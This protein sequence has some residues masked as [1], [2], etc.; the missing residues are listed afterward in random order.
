MKRP[1]SRIVCGDWVIYKAPV[2]VAISAMSPDDW[3]AVHTIYRAGI[4][5][6]QATFETTIPSW[7]EWDASKRPDCRLVAR[8]G[9]QVVGWAALNP[10]SKR[11]VYAGVAEVSI[12]VADPARGQGV[13]RLLLRALIEAAEKAGIWTLQAS[14]FP[15]NEA[16]IGLFLA[17][18]FRIVGY[19]EHIGK[20][21]GVWRDTI[22]MEKRSTHSES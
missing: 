10:V 13:G 3:E 8:F 7:M 5:T 12:Y 18:G 2:D 22:L 17:C 4:E 6:G 1:R 15:E 20:H 19:R 9:D 21:H 14:I 11:E 16:S